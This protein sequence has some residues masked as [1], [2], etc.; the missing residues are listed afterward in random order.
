MKAIALPHAGETTP[1]VDNVDR[2]YSPTGI[3]LAARGS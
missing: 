2:Y 1:A 3:P